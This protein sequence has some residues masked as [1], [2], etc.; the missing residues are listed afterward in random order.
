MVS[1]NIFNNLYE[2]K[3]HS[4][5]IKVEGLISMVSQPCSSHMDLRDQDM[6]DKHFNLQKLSS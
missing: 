5:K 4:T 6:L 3:E 1:F 2:W